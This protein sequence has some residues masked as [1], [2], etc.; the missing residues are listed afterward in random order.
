MFQ[1]IYS[2]QTLPNR[3]EY[4]G[5]FDGKHFYNDSIA[6]VPEAAIAALHSI[7]NVQTIILGGYDRGIHLPDLMT[8]VAKSPVSNVIFTGPSGKR[9]MEILNSHF[10][11]HEKAILY[12][13]NY[14]GLVEKAV[15]ITPPNSACL[16]SP[17]SPSFDSF[18][19]FEQRGE[20]FKEIIK[21]NTT[22]VTIIDNLT[23]VLIQSDIVW[24]ERDVNFARY[25]KLLQQVP[26]GVHIA[27]LPETFCRGF[28]SSAENISEQEE[29][30]VLSWMQRQAS[31][32][33]FALCGTAT[34]RENDAVYNRF[35]FV[36]PDGIFYQYDKRHLFGFGGENQQFTAGNKR[37]VIPYLGWNFFPIICYDIRFPVWIRNRWDEKNGYEYDILLLCA[38]WPAV[39]SNILDAL[40]SARAIEN[41]CYAAEV[42]RIGHD[43]SNIS[44]NGLSQIIDFKGDVLSKAKEGVEEII[45]AT[46]SKS[47]LT[48]FRA[49]YFFGPD[50]DR[51]TI[52]D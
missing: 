2:F 3:L 27:L 18:Q 33:S 28:N 6:T 47:A 41:Q 9:M 22:Q 49:K 38:N 35:Y 21:K 17:A 29:T 23:I 10:P 15:A 50:Q 40:I 37:I 31:Y 4:I 46:C 12:F 32:H 20:Y 42:N 30:I 43:D 34:I 5:T 8:A 45:T 26:K 48:Q 14:N 13:E 7:E 52:Y 16:L 39:R 24:E 44:Y 11:C 25:E 1:S 36:Q 51:F 19:N